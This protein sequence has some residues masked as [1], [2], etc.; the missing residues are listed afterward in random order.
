MYQHGGETQ[1][2]INSFAN[3]KGFLG[4]FTSAWGVGSATKDASGNILG[5]S[6]ANGSYF[7][8]TGNGCNNGANN[9]PGCNVCPSGASMI[10]G[11]CNCS[12][13]AT[14]L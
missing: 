4:F 12:N 5:M 3:Y 10:N 2:Y 1:L 9:Y 11:K 13:G 7:K 6:C 8:V 14:G